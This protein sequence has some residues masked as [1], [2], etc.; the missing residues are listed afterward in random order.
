MVKERRDPLTKS[1][2]SEGFGPRH[3]FLYSCMVVC[4]FTLLLLL[5]PS[6]GIIQGREPD[7]AAHG[8]DGLTSSVSFMPVSGHSALREREGW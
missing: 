5:F 8:L 2:G 1:F 6:R 3:T 7:C 4:V